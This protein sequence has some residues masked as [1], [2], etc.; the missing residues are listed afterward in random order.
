METR[1][2]LIRG[3]PL[4]QIVIFPFPPADSSYFSNNASDL[5]AEGQG[6]SRAGLSPVLNLCSP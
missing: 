4:L 3:W 5:F 2:R 6:L 1:V